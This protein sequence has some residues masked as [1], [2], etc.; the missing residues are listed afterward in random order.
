MWALHVGLSG[1][2]ISLSKSGRRIH[3]VDALLLGLRWKD[4][5]RTAFSVMD[6]LVK[7]LTKMRC[8]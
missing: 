7:V 5:S 3:I 6:L 4:L 8:K 2:R 1:L